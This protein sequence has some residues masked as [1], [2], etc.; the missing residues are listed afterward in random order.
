VTLV[1]F[2][3][4]RIMPGGPF[5]F[6]GDK[7]LPPG[8]VRNLEAK[9]HLD[10]PMWKQF[11]SY[12]IGDEFKVGSVTLYDLDPEK[13]S[14]SN[15]VLRGDLGPT[16]RQRGRTVNDIVGETFPL[17]AQLGVLALLLGMLIGIPAG[18]FAALRQNSWADY[19]ATFVAVLGVSIPSLVLS[20]LFIW[21]F[22]LKLG[23][24]PVAGWGAKPP[25]FQNMFLNPNFDWL[26]YFSYAVMPVF[27]L[28]TGVSAI[29]ARLTRASLLQV[30]REDYIR[31]A[32]A[33]G[34]KEQLVIYRHALKNSLIPVATV[35]G[36]I[37]AGF[38]TGTLIVEQFFGLNG[39]GKHFVQSVFNRDYAVVLGTALVYSVILVFSNLLVDLSYGFLDPR[40]RLE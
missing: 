37:F 15:G 22:A 14:Y 3:L 18:V 9:Y 17:S 6:V 19:S 12:M 39:L 31:T 35:I 4:A 16:F 32:R 28:G 36:P 8:V 10:W 1:T 20:P 26:A 13:P 25:Y 23:W 5:D 33:K 38:V 34:L 30:I 29:F 7:S 21:L 11:V 40:I 2:V 27:V 24:F